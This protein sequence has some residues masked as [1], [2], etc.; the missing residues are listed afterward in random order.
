MF[1]RKKY[2]I[3]LIIKMIMIGM[4][5][6]LIMQVKAQ[7]MGTTTSQT[8]FFLYTKNT[9]ITY[10]LNFDAQEKLNK[11]NPL[12]VKAQKLLG[13]PVKDLIKCRY[14]G[15]DGFEIRLTAYQKMPFYLLKT[16]A[17]RTYKLYVKEGADQ[18]L[19]KR[20]SLKINQGSFKQPKYQYI[21]LVIA[22]NEVAK[23]KRL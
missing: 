1:S 14:I 5:L 2:W 15:S 21:D 17:D 11:G 23:E 7:Q 18:L 8:L 16:N 19:L 13:A 6:L 3:D 9:L 12:K 20:I 22:Q 4:L 10:E